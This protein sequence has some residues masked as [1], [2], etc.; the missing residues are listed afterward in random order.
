MSGSLTTF[1]LGKESVYGTPVVST[2]F[3]EIMKE[4][5]KGA[6]NRMQAEALSSSYVDRSDRYAIAAKGAAGSVDVEV[7]TKNFGNWLGFMLGT[8][9]TTGPTDT[10][11]YVHT[12]TIGNLTGKSFT[13]QVGRAAYDGT[14][15]PW[16]YEGGKVTGWEFS[17]AVDQTLKASLTLDFEKES[18]PDSFSP[19]K[20]VV[21]FTPAS[22]G[23]DVWDYSGANGQT[24]TINDGS[25]AETV[26]L[27]TDCT[28]I[29]GVVSAVD[30]AL[31]TK[32]D[33]SADSTKVKIQ[34]HTAGAKTFVIGGTSAALIT[35]SSGYV[36]TPGLADPYSLITATVPTGAEVLAW[37]GGTITIAGSTIDI[38]DFT[39]KVDN[40]LKTDR[41]YINSAGSK[42][43]PVQDGK[44]KI[45]WSFKTPYVDNSWW[46]KVSAATASGATGAISA[47]WTGSTLA[48]SATVYPSLAIT[49]PVG[50]FDEGVPTVDGPSMLEP[51]YSGVGL[52]NGTDSAIT[53][54]YTTTDVTVM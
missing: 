12:G 31:S 41:W 49:I 52:Y 6:Y 8:V 24:F 46:K 50:R 27:N 7:L 48:G 1:G 10:T 20:A 21:E 22:A 35:G 32:Y 14:L 47:T 26:A 54:A 28:N 39:V 19:T 3:Y 53:V 30:T 4:D 9:Q 51:S 34:A 43:E 5:L 40:A 18:N 38:S 44:R 23:S 29:A 42:K 33:V 17:N 37:Q 11:A 16:T 13:A 15:Y 45:T 36:N 2:A 25:G